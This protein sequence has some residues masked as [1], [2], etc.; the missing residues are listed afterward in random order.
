MLRYVLFDTALFEDEAN[1][2]N[3]QKRVL[4]LLEALVWCNRLYLQNH[5]ETPLIYQSGI[6]YI[7]PEQFER[8]ELPE[9][10][11]VRKYM[12][13]KG[14]PPSVME[15]FKSMADQLGAGEHF[16]EIPR[17]IEHGGGDCD[18]V[19]AWRCA[20]LREHGIDAKPYITWRKRPDG[21]TTY[22]V[23]VLWP[24]GTH[25]DP[26]LLLG[27]GGAAREPDRLAEEEKLGERTADFIR[28]I[29]RKRLGVG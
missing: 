23:V 14:A 11:M 20:E 1:R 28:G 6:K 22:H 29:A 8:A 16:R 2:D 5:P 15:A 27:M 24:D 7:V 26:S 13:D 19:A 21:G 3:S 10:S 17:I 18:N 9:V 4:C 12:R 25:E